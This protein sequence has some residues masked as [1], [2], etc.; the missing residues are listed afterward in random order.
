MNVGIMALQGNYHQHK[1][2]M[3]TLGIQNTLIRHAY[4]FDKCDALIIPGGESST[5][6]KQIDRQQLREKL[7]DFAIANPVFGTCA[8]MIM[9]S[10]SEPSNNMT[11]LNIMDFQVERNAWGRQVHSFS[12]E[13]LLDFDHDESFHAVFIRAPKLIKIGDGVKVLSL[14][15][16]E[17]VLLSNGKHLVS[18]FHP[19]IGNDYR[20][21]E[22]FINLIHERKQAFI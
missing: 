2:V 3:E 18:S 20:I 6:S 7:N 9:L 1:K 11:P 21:H 8:G 22:Y 4:E 14:F 5:I 13:V 16:N 15:N 12:A 17:P 19:E 10:S